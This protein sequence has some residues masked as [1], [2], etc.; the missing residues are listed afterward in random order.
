[1]A[2]AHKP[3]SAREAAEHVAATLRRAGHA[4]LLAGG[5]VRDMLMGRTPADYD[6]AT[7]AVPARVTSLFRRTLLVGEQFGVV[8]VVLGKNRVEVATF[9]S[10]SGYADGR[11]PADVRFSDARQDAARRDFT[12]NGMFL[13]P[14]TGEVIDY[15]DGRADLAAR[16]IRAI[17]EPAQRFTED[18][19]RMLRA[20]R[21]GCV[22]DFAIEEETE[23]A[24]GKLAGLIRD[25]SAERIWQEWAK[26]LANSNRATGWRLAQRTGLVAAIWPDL[27]DCADEIG[28]RMGQLPPEA[29]AAPGL[30]CQFWGLPVEA[31][32]ERCRR[33]SLDNARRTSVAWLVEHGRDV[34]DAR[35]DLV[36][37][38]KRLATGEWTRLIQFAGSLIGPDDS[39]ARTNLAANVEAAGR[40]DPAAVA[41]EP[42]IN[43]H[44]VMSM[45]QVEG[46]RIGQT[47]AAVYDAQLAEQIA[48]REEALTLAREFLQRR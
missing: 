2:E 13:D 47:L 42:L 4:A 31:V 41:P 38:K 24:I 25:V 35:L 16:R 37:L 43:G 29:D 6:V 40:V 20:V 23:A 9:R 3:R 14:A 45:G 39:A 10:E 12:I 19:L 22:L 30:A 33:L 34:L 21:F 11:H 48:S 17:G 46:P 44:D 7:D 32:H 5:C 15:V 8:V 28:Q 1:M 26:V 36:T 27:V 18:H